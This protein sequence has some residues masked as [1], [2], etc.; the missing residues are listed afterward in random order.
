MIKDFI[1]LVKATRVDLFNFSGTTI[2]M[3]NIFELDTTDEI[4]CTIHKNLVTNKHI[5]DDF[6]EIGIPKLVT[7]LSRY[8]SIRK[9]IKMNKMISTIVITTK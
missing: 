1:L 5:F 6:V 3:K 9:I 4:L 8:K 7:Y 2:I